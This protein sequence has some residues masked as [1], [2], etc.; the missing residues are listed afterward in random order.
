MLSSG[1]RVPCSPPYEE[2]SNVVGT[3]QLAAKEGLFQG[4]L[5]G[6]P[7]ARRGDLVL[8]LP[9]FQWGMHGP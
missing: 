8:L 9:N 7:G 2:F 1:G 6:L 4:V 3:Q 5:L